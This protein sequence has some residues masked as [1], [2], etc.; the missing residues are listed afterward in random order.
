MKTNKAFLRLN[1]FIGLPLAC[2][3]PAFFFIFVFLWQSDDENDSD[4]KESKDPRESVEMKRR[5]GK[6][7]EMSADDVQSFGKS[8]KEQ[9]QQGQQ[10]E[11]GSTMFMH[12]NYIGA[13]LI[14]L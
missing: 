2:G 11:E 10:G 3:N 13:D 14:K 1:F 8:D 5:I 4:V 6:A 7:L 12:L 9:H